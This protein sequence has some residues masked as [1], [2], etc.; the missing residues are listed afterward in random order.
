M[1]VAQ[2]L[3]DD[4]LVLETLTRNRNAKLG[5]STRVSAGGRID[6]GADVVAT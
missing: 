6:A 2:R 3:D 4:P 5:V 1:R